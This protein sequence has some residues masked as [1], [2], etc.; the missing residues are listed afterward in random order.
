LDS[1][2]PQDHPERIR[3][4]NLLDWMKNGGSDF[5]KLKLQ[6]YAE[7]YRGVHAK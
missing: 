1:V 2:L 6:Y 3:F 7:S 4:K 5:S